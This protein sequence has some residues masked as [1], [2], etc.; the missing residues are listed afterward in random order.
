MNF[1]LKDAASGAKESVEN[2]GA[3]IRDKAGDAKDYVADKASGKTLSFVNVKSQIFI[4]MSCFISDVKQS[5]KQTG[6]K[7][8]EKAQGKIHLTSL[9]FGVSEI[10]FQLIG[11]PDTKESFKDVVK[12]GMESAKEAGSETSEKTSGQ[13]FTPGGE[14]VTIKQPIPAEKISKGIW[15]LDFFFVFSQSYNNIVSLSFKVETTKLQKGG[16]PKLWQEQQE[17][18]LQ[19]R[20]TSQEIRET[21]TK[22]KL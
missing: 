2:V 16:H 5:A 21:Q 13:E 20:I 22:S 15:N 18:E 8:A 7:M 10:Y 11:F 17:P 1:G 4:W 9:F 6:S 14:T 19:G 12:R 3:K